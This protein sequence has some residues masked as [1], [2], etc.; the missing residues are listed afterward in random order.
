MM[1]TPTRLFSRR[2]L[3][4]QSASAGLLGLSGFR[5]AQAAELTEVTYLMPAPFDLPA[6]APW[7]IA[8]HNGYYAE[9]GLKMKFLTVRGGADVAKQVGAG[10]A[11]VGGA[12]GDTPI[13]VRGNGVPVKSV[14][15]LGSGPLALIATHADSPIQSVKD[16]KGKTV[17]T[18]DYASSAYYALLGALKRAGLTKSD[19]NIQ[20]AGPAGVWQLLV[21]HKA[22]AFVGTMDFVLPAEAAGARIALLP[23]S[24]LPP[25]MAQ[26]ILASEDA[27]KNHP[28]IVRG[29]V[30]ATLRGMRDCMK[31]PDKALADFIAAVPSAQGR[32][33]QVQRYF[34]YTNK[35]TFA[36]QPVPGR[37]DRKLLST[38]LDFYVKMRV[39]PKALPLDD[40]YTDQFITAG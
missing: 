28:E 38:V 8:D 9:E 24:E 35:V 1:H 21:T 20:A 19:V 30:R 36:N 37:M 14:A 33:E 23:Q 22:D 29:V 11:L 39:V 12:V 34:D 31:S 15:L 17:T 25:T 18:N 26:A 10:N 13:F 7:R 40:L 4:L 27:I 16:L 32:R 5:G 6:F 2:R 3:F